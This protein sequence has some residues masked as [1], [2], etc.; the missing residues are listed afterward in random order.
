MILLH[1]EQIATKSCMLS[2][3]SS[4]NDSVTF[5]T[6]RIYVTLILIYRTYIS[7]WCLHDYRY[8]FTIGLRH[9]I[10]VRGCKCTCVTRAIFDPSF[11][12]KCFGADNLWAFH[13]SSACLPKYRPYILIC[14][15]R[16]IS[17]AIYDSSTPLILWRGSILAFF[18]F[19]RVPPITVTVYSVLLRSLK[20]GKIRPSA[21]ERA[22]IGRTSMDKGQGSTTVFFSLST[23]KIKTMC[24]LAQLILFP[25]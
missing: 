19:D 9:K 13:H 25:H 11:L 23:P 15:P 18:A 22:R 5:G 16:D 14:M 2:Y 24:D 20:Y 17:F 12:T 8:I 4:V 6:N 7:R 21:L 3:Y 10:K 1:S